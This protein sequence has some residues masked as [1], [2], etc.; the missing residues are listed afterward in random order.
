MLGVLVLVGIAGGVIFFKM[1]YKTKLQK[2]VTTLKTREKY[3]AVL[4]NPA[5]II[6]IVIM[7]IITATSVSP[8]G[9]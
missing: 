2:G 9:A 5:M 6:A 3:G 1:N 7:L 4:S 8:S